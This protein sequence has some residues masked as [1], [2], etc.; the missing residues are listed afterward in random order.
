[1]NPIRKV[2]IYYLGNYGFVTANVR[3][4]RDKEIRD[5]LKPLLPADITIEV[6]DES[7]SFSKDKSFCSYETSKKIINEIRK[8]CPVLYT[9][10]RT[11]FDGLYSKSSVLEIGITSI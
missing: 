7:I 9:S 1:M 5:I 3:K 8:I 10:Y 4:S 11:N 2:V 6:D